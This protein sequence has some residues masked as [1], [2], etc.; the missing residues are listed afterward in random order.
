MPDLRHAVYGRASVW[1]VCAWI[2]AFSFSLRS[3]LLMAQENRIVD[4]VDDSRRM[5]LKGNVHP[6]AQGQYD[7]GPVNPS[8]KLSYITLA[9]SSGYC[10]EPG[11]ARDSRYIPDEL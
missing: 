4:R 11:Q 8:L 3:P 6:K 9:L 2:F 7:Q 1:R 5:L 10:L